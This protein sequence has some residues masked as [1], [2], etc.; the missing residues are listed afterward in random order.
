VGVPPVP[1]LPIDVTTHLLLAL[2][3]ATA[4][5]LIEIIGRFAKIKAYRRYVLQGVASIAFAI[6]YF[7]VV[8]GTGVAIM[9]TVLAPVLFLHARR[10]KQSATLR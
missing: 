3:P 7:V 1:H 4:I 5:F 6:A 9:L 8:D 2:Y 10:V